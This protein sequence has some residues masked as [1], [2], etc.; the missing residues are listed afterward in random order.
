ML[1]EE[2]NTLLNYLKKGI[3]LCNLTYLMGLILVGINGQSLIEQY[4]DEV[5]ENY[6]CNIVVAAGNEGDKR[7]HYKGI[8]SKEVEFNVGESIKSLNLEL[9][10]N[11]IGNLELEIVSPNGNRTGVM[12]GKDSLYRMVLL[13]TEVEIEYIKPTPSI[14]DERIIINLSGLNY[15][16]GGIWKIIIRTD[17]NVEYDIWLPISEGSYWRYYFFKLWCKH[18]QYTI[19]ST[20]YRAISVGAYND[21]NNTIASFSGRGFTREISYV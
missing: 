2:L 9:Y 1:Q 5:V 6:V 4:I 16:D 13:N 15:V 7:H 20:A 8:G 17:E 3:C 18:K 21:E 14:L 10:K 12:T 11:Y 19:P